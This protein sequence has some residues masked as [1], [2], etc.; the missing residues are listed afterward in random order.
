MVA[1]AVC[2]MVACKPKTAKKDKKVNKME[3]KVNEF[4]TVELT[5]DFSKLDE[6]KMKM[7][8][9]LKQVAMIMEDIYWKQAYGS[10]AEALALAKGDKAT[11]DFIRIN[12]GPWERLGDNKP[13]IKEVEAKPKGANF[14]PKNMTKKEFDT[15]KDESKTSLYTVIRRDANKKLISV[16]YHKAY[17]AETAKAVKLIREAAELAENKGLI[18]YLTLRAK[19]LENDEYFES[20]MAWM[21]MKTNQI[22]FV[23]GPIENYEDALFGYKAAHESFILVKDMDWSKKLDRFISL[24]PKLQKSLPVEDKYKKETPGSDSDLGAYDALY[25]GGDCNAGSKT[26]A[27]NLPNDEKVQQA[28]GARR[29][30]LKNVMKAKFDKILTPICKVV[31]DP[32]QQKHVKFNAFFENTMFHEVAHGLGIKYTLDGKGTVDD[33]LKAYSTTIEE[34]K[35]DIVGLYLVTKLHEMGEMKIDLM[36]NYVTF[37]AGIFRSVR[38]GAASSHGKANM[39]R[40]NYFNEKGAFTRTAEGIYKVDFEK[41]KAAVISLSKEILIM[42][43]DGNYELAEKTVKEKSPMPKILKDDLARIAKAGIPRDIRFIQGKGF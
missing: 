14:Y 34:G 18:K 21:S 26:I 31:I 25:Y 39:I 17:A 27:I 23:V 5:T 28:K 7:L 11:E 35:A 22:D 36:D 19:A 8:G 13:F 15:L 10:R 40:F 9:I 29:L 16:P 32:S 3:Q 1:L 42:Q 37:L 43:G 20:D 38:F 33:A 41:M 24:L 6:K 4:A 12:Y 30:Q 2:S